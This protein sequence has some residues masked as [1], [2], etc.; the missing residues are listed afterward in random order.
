MATMTMEMTT[1]HCDK[2]P[3]QQRLPQHGPSH[4]SGLV[5]RSVLCRGQSIRLVGLHKA[6]W[7]LSSG[8]DRNLGGLH[9][10]PDL[11]TR[12]QAELSH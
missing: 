12:D 9:A 5:W 2:G 8:V 11:L 3:P 1:K 10:R 4:Q 6:R 7:A